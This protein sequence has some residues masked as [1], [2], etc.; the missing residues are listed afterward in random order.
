VKEAKNKFAHT[1]ATRVSFIG[2][3]SCE[4][5]HNSRLA[6]GGDSPRLAAGNNVSHLSFSGVKA[7]AREKVS[8]ANVG[9]QAKSANRSRAF[10]EM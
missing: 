8:V 9:P 6:E 1:L 2:V 7:V 4:A 10:S 3:I 5:V